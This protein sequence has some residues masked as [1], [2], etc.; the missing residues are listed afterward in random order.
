MQPSIEKPAE[1]FGPVAISLHWVIAA[2]MVPCLA[3]GLISVQAE[4]AEVTRSTLVLHQSIGTLIFALALARLVWRMT[5]PAPALPATMP[6]SHKIAA[7]ATHGLLYVTL[8][9]FPVTGY[10]SLAARGRDISIFGLFD[11]PQLIERSRLLS[12]SSRDLHDYGQYA[13]YA[14]LAL[15]VAA[16][17]YHHFVVKDDILRRMRWRPRGRNAGKAS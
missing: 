15:H 11:L 14:L 8:Y 7:A 4:T 16:A 1:T 3:F 5:H 13:F 6:R 10:V 17:L 12:A 2:A 9:A